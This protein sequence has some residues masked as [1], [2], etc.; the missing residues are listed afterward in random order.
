MFI[1]V[2]HLRSMQAI[3]ETGSLARAAS[4]LHVTQS[5]L[6]HQIK[7]IERH[8][9]TP[10]F[11]RTSK[12]L[13]L[14]PA[15]QRLVDLARRLL[16]ELESM[17]RELQ[18]LASGKSGRLHLTI[19]CHACFDWLLPLLD[20]FRQQWPEVEVDI[21][22]GMSFDPIPA[23]Q[24]GEVDL[25]ISSDPVAARG[26]RFEPLFDY[27]ALLAL[28]C[29]HPLAAR[30][31][32][33]AADLEDQILLTYPVERRRLDVF[34]RFLQ[35]AGVEPAAVRP[36]ELTAMMLQLVA[37]GRGVAVLPDWVLDEPLKTGRLCARPLGEA[38]L[39][40]TLYA[41]I[42]EQDAALPFMQ[43]FVQLAREKMQARA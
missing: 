18:G 3:F 26:I 40:G 20:D 38:G 4:R 6:S 8:F 23:M 43:S 10:L 15:G 2:R 17:E 21:R 30:S 33:Q 19:E 36:V 16:P 37:S 5:A 25:V 24:R 28:A 14:T 35:P 9:D 29:S 1:D 27:Q 34:S 31:R 39:H 41:A 11:L 7:A 22:L 42:R 12:P 32:V 13:K